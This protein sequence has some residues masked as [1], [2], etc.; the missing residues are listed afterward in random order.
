MKKITW[1]LIICFPVGS[2]G[3]ES[4]CSAGDLGTSPG[5]GKSPGE[6][7][8]HPL[9]YPCLEHPMDRG[10][11]RATYRPWVLKESDTT[12]WLSTH[13]YFLKNLFKNLFYLFLAELGLRGRAG[14]PSLRPAGATAW[15][16]CS[17]SRCGRFSCGRAQAL[18]KGSAVVAHGRR[19][20][21]MWNL[22]RPGTGPVSPAL[23]GI[24]LI[25]GPPGKS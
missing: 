16:W 20:P 22:P 10:A 4:A 15:L 13:M 19:C 12:E 24:F 23:A 25:T 11:W 9:Q 1:I 17:A 6:G 2:D 21:G 5:L 8:G 3:K 14:F 7:N 18:G